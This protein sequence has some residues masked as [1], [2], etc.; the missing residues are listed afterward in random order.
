MHNEYEP[1]NSY[2]AGTPYE[3]PNDPKNEY[4]PEGAA[5][6]ADAQAGY[7][8]RDS[9]GRLVKGNAPL[10]IEIL[11]TSK[12]F[13]PHLTIYQ[14]DL[15]KVGITLNLRLI[16]PE[17]ERSAGEPAAVSDGY[18]RLGRIGFPGLRR[19]FS[20]DVGRCRKYQQHYRVQGPACR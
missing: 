20:I 7:S 4:D 9:Q 16:T 10:E 11:Y 3:N 18:F 14:E 1:E 8:S 5:E 6:I 19:E 15:R 2:D 12:T 17:T 13:E